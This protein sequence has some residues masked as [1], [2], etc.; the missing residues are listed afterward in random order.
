MK[1]G[2]REGQWLSWGRSIDLQCGAEFNITVRQHT[3][4][5]GQEQ[6][7]TSLLDHTNN[8]GALYSSQVLWA[9][10][11]TSHPALQDWVPTQTL[12]SA[13]G[14]IW[15]QWCISKHSTLEVGGGRQAARVAFVG[16]AVTNLN[17]TPGGE[18]KKEEELPQVT[19]THR[20]KCWGY[21]TPNW[22]LWNAV[23]FNW[24]CLFRSSWWRAHHGLLWISEIHISPL[25]HRRESN[26]AGAKGEEDV[27]PIWNTLM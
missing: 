10:E 25:Q 16:Y 2:P 24:T 26:G 22:G 3:S 7:L 15:A 13:R 8:F 20:R 12:K 14:N 27:I 9:A 4:P 11:P 5:L 23:C 6:G 17:F 18:S 1:D 19:L 21:E